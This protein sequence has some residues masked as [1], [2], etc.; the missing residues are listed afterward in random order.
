M[1]AILDLTG[2]HTDYSGR[3]NINYR[4]SK[5][6]DGQQTVDITSPHFLI[7]QLKSKFVVE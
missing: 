4:V 6:P 1:K 5:F 3:T 7:L 2:T